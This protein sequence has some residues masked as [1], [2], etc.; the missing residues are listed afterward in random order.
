[1]AKVM[2]CHLGDQ[3]TK[4][5]DIHLVRHSLLPSQ[6]AGFDEDTAMLDSFMWLETKGNFWP[7]ASEE[8]RPPVQRSIRN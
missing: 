6:L 5:C 8:P 2:V 7:K 4:A 1:M 3:I